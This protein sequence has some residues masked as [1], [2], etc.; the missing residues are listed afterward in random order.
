[1]KVTGNQEEYE[2]Y[3]EEFDSEEYESYN[4]YVFND[5][6]R[7]FSLYQTKYVRLLFKFH[8]TQVLV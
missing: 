2:E 8:E 4:D 6:H 5:F 7:Q 3:K 1:M